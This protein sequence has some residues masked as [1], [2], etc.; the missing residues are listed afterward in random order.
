MKNAAKRIFTCKNRCRYSRKRATFAE[1]LPKIG[2]YPTGPLPL[3]V[4]TRW[5]AYAA[6]VPLT[7]YDRLAETGP[8]GTSDVSFLQSWRLSFQQCRSHPL[9][10]FSAAAELSQFFSAVQGMYGVSQSVLVATPNSPTHDGSWMQ[11]SNLACSAG[12]GCSADLRFART[13][14][15]RPGHPVGVRLRS[16]QKKSLEHLWV[17]ACMDPEDPRREGLPPRCDK[18]WFSHMFVSLG[19]IGG[20]LGPQFFEMV[21]ST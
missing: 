9:Y 13:F 3:T 8:R 4:V 6:R 21:R 15:N 19:G 20:W 1:I 18:K 12:R 5:A 17:R 2:N 7:L 11:T 14:A 10:F 16:A